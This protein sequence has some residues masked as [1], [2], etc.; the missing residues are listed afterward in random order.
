M[1]YFSFP[2]SGPFLYFKSGEFTA[3]IPWKHKRMYHH[4]DYQIIICTKG[5]LYIQVGED[6]HIVTPNDV[7]LIPPYTTMFGYKCSTEPVDFY[8]L[9][10][11]VKKAAKPIDDDQL[12]RD[13]TPV[14]AKSF[15]PAIND[16]VI[17]PAFSHLDKPE[18]IFVLINQVLDIANSYRYTEREA[19][20][21]TTM[22]LIEL[23]HQFIEQIITNHRFSNHKIDRIKEWIRAN[24]TESLTVEQ[25]A[26]TFQLNP[27]YLTRLFKRCDHCTTLQYINQLKIETAEMLLLRTNL[28][29]KQIAAHSYFGDEKNF[30][31]RFKSQLGLTPSEFRNAYSH[32]HLNNPRID[33]TIPL[34]KQ[35][36]SML[37]FE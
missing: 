1:D 23:T 2:L 31:R 28:P 7:L 33:P 9:H 29:I 32:T 17:L 30:M 25:V 18:K 22:F 36:E 16:R 37:T 14:A 20:Y 6:K 15:A 10:F 13:V 19:D 11:F 8:W 27:D 26:R 5:P 3:D 34:P 12:I 21:A 24:I 35:L 4:G